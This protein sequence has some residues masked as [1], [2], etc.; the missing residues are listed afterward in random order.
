[1]QF[2]TETYAHLGRFR[3][4]PAECALV[5]ALLLVV[6]MAG[7]VGT[8]LL[9]LGTCILLLRISGVPLCTIGK[10][11]AVPLAFL[12]M[13]ALSLAISVSWEHS[14]QVHT[15]ATQWYLALQVCLRSLAAT[16]ALFFFSFTVPMHRTLAFLRW[17]RLPPEIGDVFLAIY[18]AIMQLA[19]TFAMLVRAQ[20][21]RLGNRHWRARLHDSG[22]LAAQ[23]FVHSQRKALALEQGLAARGFQGELRILAEPVPW[24]PF[25][26]LWAIVLP[27]SIALLG[28]GLDHVIANH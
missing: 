18:T 26:L 7:A 4:A 2:P 11:L 22:A 17:L 1:M 14:L 9:C 27:F 25:R 15:S 19:Q 20:D 23:L 6:A 21:N 16:A 28:H 8:A 24:R 13:S 10:S 3:N 12:A 5:A